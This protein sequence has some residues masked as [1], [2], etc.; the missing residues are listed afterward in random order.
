M[1]LVDIVRRLVE[2]SHSNIRIDARISHIVRLL[3]R[4]IESSEIFIY[5]LDKDK[6]LTLK[7]STEK[8]ET[9][10]ILSSYRPQLGEG[11]IGSVA[12]KR[13]TLFFNIENV[14]RRLGLLLK[15]DLDNI[16]PSYR[17]FAFYPISDESN[18]YGVL[19]L[20]SSSGTFFNSSETILL[21]ITAKELVGLFKL[22]ELYTDSK[23]RITE[24]M[25]LSEIGKV[26][27]SNR[28]IDNVLKNLALILA[29][30]F[31]ADFVRIRINEKYT[32]N[33]PSCATFGTL[34]QNLESDLQ[35]IESRVLG[36]SQPA[37]TSVLDRYILY[38]TAIVSKGTTIGVITILRNPENPPLDELD[39]VYLLQ[40]ISNYLASGLESIFLNMELKNLVHELSLAQERII[41]QEK[42]KSLGEMT[43]NIA[44]EIKNP[45]VVIGGFTKRLAKKLELKSKEKHY[46][47]IILSEVHRLEAILEEI[48]NYARDVKLEMVPKNVKEILDE[49]IQFFSHDPLWQKIRFLKDFEPEIPPILCDPHQIKQVFI[50]ILVNAHEAMAGEGTITIKTFKKII[51]EKPFV[52]IAFSDTGGGIDPLIVDNIFNPFFTTKEKGSGLGLSISNKIILSHKGKI[53]VQ[54]HPGVGATFIVYLPAPYDSTSVKQN[55][56]I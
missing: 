28:D 6:R 23:K 10:S 29:K 18:C 17:R 12:Q 38:S 11:I 3:E 51:N 32:Q 47:D 22:N 13:E 50:N 42:L 16:I 31:G 19:A 15:P 34:S 9:S 46:L 4:A 55:D 39:G 30:T 54:N 27:I 7:Y 14:P 45:L 25:T 52:G 5:V 24:L 49:L 53:E 33:L 1:D 35:R 43:A 41:E 20:L 37:N 48:L 21:E 26:L 36:L 56:K 2:I 40:T 44:H 8:T